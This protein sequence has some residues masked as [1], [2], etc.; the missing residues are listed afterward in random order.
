MVIGPL[1][2]PL[3]SFL[4]L[5]SFFFLFSLSL[6]K[7]DT[8]ARR[9]FVQTNR[10][11]QPQSSRKRVHCGNRGKYPVKRERERETW[12]SSKEAG[13]RAGVGAG[14]D[15]LKIRLT[16]PPFVES[17]REVQ[18]RP[19]YSVPFVSL[20]PPINA[21]RSLSLSSSLLL[22]L[23]PSMCTLRWMRLNTLDISF[24]SWPSL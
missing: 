14:P 8:W 7:W 23:S 16:C 24:F 17:A 11:S 9:G 10:K 22:S 15:N 21:P 1:L 5:H 20:S 18:R 19:A 13:T 3:T 6:S 12:E 2:F 4:S